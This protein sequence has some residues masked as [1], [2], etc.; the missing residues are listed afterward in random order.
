[1]MEERCIANPAVR[2]ARPHFKTADHAPQQSGCNQPLQFCGC[3]PEAH[4]HTCAERFC[5]QTH[6]C[7]FREQPETHRLRASGQTGNC[8]HA[9]F[10]SIFFENG[11]NKQNH[12]ALTASKLLVVRKKAGGG[13]R[14][15]KLIRFSGQA[16][17]GTQILSTP[18]PFL[19]SESTRA[20]CDK[21]LRLD[22]SANSAA[23]P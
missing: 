9:S 2:P 8:M 4:M 16:Y 21:S 17:H 15:R 20:V 6:V 12:T 11:I 23:I 18:L 3:W 10:Q 7:T 1:M 13:Q 19:A 22:D 5:L 14:E